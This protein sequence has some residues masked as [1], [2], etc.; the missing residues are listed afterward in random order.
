MPNFAN[1]KWEFFC[2][3]K[4]CVGKKNSGKSG[5]KNK[6]KVVCQSENKKKCAVRHEEKLAVLSI[7]RAPL[8]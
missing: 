7:V 8:P 6:K 1:K 5:E 3:T 2:A 4:I